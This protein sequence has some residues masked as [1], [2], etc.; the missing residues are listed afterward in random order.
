MSRVGHIGTVKLAFVATPGTEEVE[1]FIKTL[2]GENSEVFDWIYCSDKNGFVKPQALILEPKD[3][4]GWEEGLIFNDD[5]LLAESVGGNMEPGPKV[6]I[7]SVRF[8]FLAEPRSGEA[9]DFVSI[10]LSENPNVLDWSYLRTEDNYYITPQPISMSEEKVKS[11][12]RELDFN[13]LLPVVLKSGTYIEPMRFCDLF[14]DRGVWNEHPDYPRSDWQ[15]EVANDDTLL[16]YW[17]WVD[18]R[19]EAEDREDDDDE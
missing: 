16:G 12:D 13:Y 6:H 9:E 15:D 11:F 7:A 10:M 3:Y 8:A 14:G 19:I 5:L 18:H 4:E 2:L 1:G 17:D